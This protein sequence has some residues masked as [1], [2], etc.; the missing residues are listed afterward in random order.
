MNHKRPPIPM[1]V[2]VVLV[3]LTAGYFGIRA[4]LTKSSNTLTASGTIE[5]VEVTISPEIGG[6]VAEVMVAEGASVKTGDVLFRLDDSLLQAQRAV[7]AASLSLAQA[8]A[9]T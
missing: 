8:S 2:I 4:L 1:I 3:L 7:A 9:L 6:K 5:V